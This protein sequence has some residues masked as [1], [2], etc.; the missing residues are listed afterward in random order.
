MI[1]PT[2]EQ[3]YY[4]LLALNWRNTAIQQRKSGVFYC[5]DRDDAVFWTKIL[6]FYAPNL[7][8][9]PKYITRNLLGND[10]R[11]SSQVLKYAKYGC[12]SPDFLLFIDSD[13][14]FLLD[15]IRMDTPFL[16][17]T[18][19][20]SIENHWCY[21]PNIKPFLETKY[22]VKIDFDFELFLETFS[23]II[24]KAFIYTV[25]DRKNGSNHF[26]IYELQKLLSFADF[27]T[28][29]NVNDY[30][31]HLKSVLEI[32]TNDLKTEFSQTDFDAL[33]QYLTTEKGLTPETTYLYLRGHTIYEKVLQPILRQVKIP[34]LAA[35]FAVL[36]KNKRNDFKANLDAFTNLSPNLSFAG[37]PQLQN[38]FKL[39]AEKGFKKS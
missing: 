26:S 33:E 32:K 28:N 18:F 35:N 12:T 20:Y 27:S 24:Y 22:D 16:A 39:M 30:L 29:D 34:I 9:I 37:Y 10:S 14:H 19:T 7:D 15:D 11:G 38:I 31:T 5:E 6:K 3:D 1:T 25:L 23:K 17:H 4:K 21:A 8:F 36:P 2:N 13:Y